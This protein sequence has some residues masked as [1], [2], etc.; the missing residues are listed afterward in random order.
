M[1]TSKEVRGIVRPEFDEQEPDNDVEAALHDERVAALYRH[2]W[3]EARPWAREAPLV[4]F[5]SDFNPAHQMV[6]RVFCFP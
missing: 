4:H 3:P 6:G 1:L 2:G 5:K